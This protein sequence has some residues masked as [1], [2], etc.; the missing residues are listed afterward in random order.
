MRRCVHRHHPKNRTRLYKTELDVKSNDWSEKFG[1]LA[2]RKARGEGEDEAE[3]SNDFRLRLPCVLLCMC[4]IRVSRPRYWVCMC[5]QHII[6]RVPIAHTV[7]AYFLPYV[8]CPLLAPFAD[9]LPTTT[10]RCKHCC[11]LSQQRRG[12][13]GGRLWGRRVWW[14]QQGAAWVTQVYCFVWSAAA[15][16]ENAADVQVVEHDSNKQGDQ[17][18]GCVYQPS[19]TVSDVCRRS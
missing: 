11:W 4:P 10:L 18:R 13:G 9:V 1:P 2:Q 17:E 15:S 7:S 5:M 14:C 6:A 16:T 8:C 19:T 3:V 12:G